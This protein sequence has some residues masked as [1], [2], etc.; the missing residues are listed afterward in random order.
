VLPIDAQGQVIAVTGAA[1]PPFAQD[2]AA[3]Q[4][5]LLHG[6]DLRTSY[7]SGV[8]LRLLTYRIDSPNGPLLLQAGRSVED[9]ARVLRQS[10]RLALLGG[11]EQPGFRMGELGLAGK[12]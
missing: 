11:L 10:V 7:E 6:S 12:T 8:P 5:A 9:Q 1:L 3:S 4:A 2:Q